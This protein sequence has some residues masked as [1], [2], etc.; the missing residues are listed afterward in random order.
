MSFEGIQKIQH[1][2]YET[3]SFDDLEKDV[4]ASAVLREQALNYLKNKDKEWFDKEYTGEVTADGY[5]IDKDGNANTKPTQCLGGSGM[6]EVLNATRAELARL[7]NSVVE[8]DDMSEMLTLEAI[9]ESLK[10]SQPIE[11]K[12]RRSSGEIESGWKIVS[13]DEDGLKLY[14]TKE[15][16]GLK[17][18]AF[19]DMRKWNIKQD[20]YEPN[21]EKS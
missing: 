17:R 9:R 20:I 18:I 4:V 12:V 3:M 11:I 6:E 14:V 21:W 15:G 10:K 1:S 13:I 2:K 5:L 8:T 7:D 19:E 16:I